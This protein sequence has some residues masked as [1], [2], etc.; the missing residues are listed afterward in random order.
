MMKYIV[1]NYLSNAYRNV[2]IKFSWI[3]FFT[4]ETNKKYLRSA[5]SQDWFTSLYN[6][7]GLVSYIIC[8]LFITTVSYWANSVFFTGCKNQADKRRINVEAYLVSAQPVSTLQ[9][10]N[11]FNFVTGVAVIACLCIIVLFAAIFIVLQVCRN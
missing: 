10:V 2:L 1:I 3:Q 11:P 9:L 4:I 8:L 6:S 7:F 5:V